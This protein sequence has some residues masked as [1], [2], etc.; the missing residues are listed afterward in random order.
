[1]SSLL[2]AL[3]V[4]NSMLVSDYILICPL[5]IDG[6]T[7]SLGITAGETKNPSR[8]MPRIIKFVFWRCVSLLERFFPRVDTSFSILLFYLLS[9]LV[10]GLNGE[11]LPRSPYL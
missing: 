4:R 3:P 7:E 1:M 11:P 9:I 2:P 5:G 8:N 6:G 10:I